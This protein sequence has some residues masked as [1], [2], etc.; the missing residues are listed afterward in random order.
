[1]I[2][3]EKGMSAK[4]SLSEEVNQAMKLDTQINLS[5]DK[6]PVT[7]TFA[8]CKNVLTSLAKDEA[9]PIY[10][11]SQIESAQTKLEA[12]AQLAL[13]MSTRMQLLF[14]DPQKAPPEVGIIM[15]MIATMVRNRYL[16]TSEIVVAYNYNK[17][18]EK[19]GVD[20]ESIFGKMGL[21]RFKSITS[22]WLFRVKPMS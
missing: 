22:E 7:G 1:M 14:P 5:L 17:F 16:A 3:G 12:E 10:L 19:Y 13:T 2:S 6:L 15:I 4:Q 21:E 20:I 11:K 8:I 9:L 18:H